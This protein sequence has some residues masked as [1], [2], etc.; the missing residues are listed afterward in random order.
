MI[1]NRTHWLL[2]G[3]FLWSALVLAAVL[4]F[5]VSLLPWRLAIMTVA[6]AVGGMVLTG[7]FSLL[8]LFVLLRTNRRHGSKHC[9][10]SVALSLPPL[11]GVLLVGM[12]GAKTP[13]IHDITT[14]TNNQPNFR[15][16]QTLRRSS[17]NSLVYPG[18]TTA[19]QQQQA[20]P[21]IKPIETSLPSAEAFAQSLVAAEKLRWRVVG[22]YREEGLIEA[23]A[24]TLVFGF[25]DD[26]VIRVAAVGNGSRIDLR[27][28]SRVGVGD[29]GTNAERIRAFRHTFNSMQP[30]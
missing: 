10:L 21:D 20:Y 15:A 2:K 30:N 4:G 13:P 14:D 24:R 19:D 9:L 17:D 23:E 29:L 25:I 7:F 18:R 6:V 28:A 22:L 8:L 16:A 26:I 12:Q 3:Q 11:I 27:S 1:T 5:R